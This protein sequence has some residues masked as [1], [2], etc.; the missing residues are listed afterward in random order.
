MGKN[1]ADGRSV[2]KKKEL[3]R[4]YAQDFCKLTPT[5]IHTM[6]CVRI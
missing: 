6:Q 4:T 2:H 1:F 5:E 3:L